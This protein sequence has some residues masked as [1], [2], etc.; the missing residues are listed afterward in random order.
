M[1]YTRAYVREDEPT[2][3][4]EGVIPDPN[5]PIQWVASTEGVKSDGLD[6]RADQW[7][8]TRF[9]KHPVILWAHDYMGQ[10]LPIGTGRAHVE[11]AELRVDV[12]YD[13]DDDFAQ[14]VRAKSLKGMIAGSVGWEVVKE[15]D[16]GAMRNQLLEFSMVPVP[17]DPDALPARQMRAWREI[18]RDYE[19][20]TP[21]GDEPWE[22]TAA[23]M[24]RLFT[25]PCGDEPTRRHAYNEL[26]RQYRQHDRTA[27]EY[28]PWSEL[29]ALD[30]ATLAGLFLEG[31]PDV[32]ARAFEEPLQLTRERKQTVLEALAVIQTAIAGA[33][34]PDAAPQI[35]TDD[36]QDTTLTA[37]RD[38]L[39]E[40]TKETQ[41]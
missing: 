31:E 8:L 22:R 30:R 18:I 17:M 41:K 9:E 5:A 32:C 26:E 40:A 15:G 27:P 29:A 28:V 7:D 39:A 6:L 16:K 38:A 34:E 10:N 3:Q 20:Q 21:G 11:G 35:T 37:L 12:T 33:R 2:E 23:E 25:E 19:R 14:R 1:R 24:V 36:Y 4:P 13:S